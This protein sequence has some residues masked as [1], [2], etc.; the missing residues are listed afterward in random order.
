MKKYVALIAV[1]FLMHPTT[2][3]SKP[4]ETKE[5]WLCDSELT[6]K[7]EYKRHHHKKH[8]HKK[9]H[10]KHH[11]EVYQ[12]QALVQPQEVVVEQSA[13]PLMFDSAMSMTCPTTPV[14]IRSLGYD[15]KVQNIGGTKKEISKAS[16]QLVQSSEA[17]SDDSFRVDLS[18]TSTVPVNVKVENKK[19]II[20]QK[21]CGQKKYFGKNSQRGQVVAIDMTKVE[22]KSR[23]NV[24]KLPT[25]PLHALYFEEKDKVDVGFQYQHAGGS[26]SSKGHSEDLSSLVFGECPIRVRNILLVSK[27][28]ENGDVIDYSNLT[29]EGG[30]LGGVAPQRLDFEAEVDDFRLSLGY[31]RHFIKNA[32][33]LGI[34]VPFVT[35]KHSLTLTTTV[36]QV[37]NT[38]AQ[39][40]ELY[41]NCF[42]NFVEDILAKKGIAFTKSDSETGLGD[43]ETFLNLEIKAKH[44]E[45]CITGVKVLFP[46][47]RSRNLNKLWAPELGN[48]G[49]TELSAYAGLLL[50]RNRWLNPHLLVQGTYCFSASV[51]RRIPSII[52]FSETSPSG[53]NDLS[54]IVEM[55]DLVRTIGTEPGPAT[56]FKEIDSCVRLFS[57][58]CTGGDDI[59]IRKGPEAELRIGNIFERF[60]C[61]KAF[62]DI[63]YDL[64]LKGSDYIAEKNLD[65][66]FYPE[67]LKQ[68]TFQVEHRAG[69]SLSYQFDNHVRALLGGVYT[70]AGYNV[71]KTIEANAA[72]SVEF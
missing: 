66:K 44:L 53:M 36:N 6:K 11:G 39:F 57:S 19:L 67:I 10:H 30:Y 34:R 8:H 23:E 41:G 61:R 3:F 35:R 58:R 4:K 56:S 37:A 12:P 40:I 9:H 18:V 15:V 65:C 7:H 16:G 48:G 55:G 64:R 31:V 68:N 71:P 17:K 25:W 60:I 45:R 13:I 72:I 27:L 52:E 42:E 63:Y 24:Y 70:F 46:T 62:L 28:V 21:D 33:S 20:E 54:N 49:F 69:L 22:S 47:A 59:K 1:L 43:I 32:V 29:S 26:F 14:D 2:G 51:P 5:R 50:P 38:N